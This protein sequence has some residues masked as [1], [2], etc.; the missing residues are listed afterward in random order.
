[1]IAEIEPKGKIAEVFTDLA[2][3][4]AGPDETHASRSEAFFDPLIAKL[5]RKRHDWPPDG[6][7][8]AAERSRAR[9]GI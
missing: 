6:R 7:A 5:A 2:S 9:K 4:L 3:A 8:V 1:M